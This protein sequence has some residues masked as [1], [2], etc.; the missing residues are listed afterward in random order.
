[1]RNL[2]AL[3][4]IAALL[5]AS[6]AAATTIHVPDDQPTI[7]AG[8]AAAQAGDSVIVAY[9]EYYEHELVLPSGVTLRTPATQGIGVTLFGVG[10]GRFITGNGLAAGSRVEGFL[11]TGGNMDQA[12]ANGG[13]LHFSNSTIEI[14][15]CWL[16]GNRCDYKGGGLF[17]DDC[18][19]TV[20]STSFTSNEGENGGGGGL[21]AHGGELTLRDCQFHWNGGVDGGAALL[22]NNAPLIED[23]V[24]HGND[25]LF[26][27]GALM[28]T[29]S[30]PM[31]RNCTLVRND[32]YQGGGLWGSYDSRPALENCVVAFNTD[33]SGLYAYPDDFHPTEISV[34][35]CDVYGNV[36]GGYGGTLADQTGMNGN[37]AS[38]PL[39]CDL[40]NGEFGGLLLA[41]DSPCLPGGNGCGVLMG[42]LPQGCEV[43]TAVPPAP[44][45]ARLLPNWPN[46]FN[47]STELRFSL[48]APGAVTLAI[49]DLSGRCLRVLL[50]SIER[51]AGE[52]ALRWDGRNAAGEA[53]PSGIYLVRLDAAGQQLSQKVTLLK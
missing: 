41:A 4:P 18:V 17:L 29:N 44:A 51:P 27:G 13:A 52:Q 34:S 14:R 33:G 26:W 50:D 30:A 23:C 35:C 3:I 21:A 8:L 2:G 9:G 38:H 28:L 48:A 1:M 19:A 12:G 22:R 6:S 45:Q 25:A 32:A 42:A 37:I 5:L 15:D 7:A 20:E 16:F 47:P 43:A 53:L 46:P 31:I 11:F 39:F 24:F 40:D 49:H 36:E 10:P